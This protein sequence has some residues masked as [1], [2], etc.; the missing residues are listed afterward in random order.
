MHF[1]GQLA[2]SSH[3]HVHVGLGMC[4]FFSMLNHQSQSL[5][6]VGA[7]ERTGNTLV[8]R[9]SLMSSLD[10]HATVVLMPAAP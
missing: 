4:P 1:S 6:A 10:R 9:G 8:W 5:Y 7:A 2:C 3:A